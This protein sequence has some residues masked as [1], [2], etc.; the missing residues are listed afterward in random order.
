MKTVRSQLLKIRG[1]LFAILY[2][3]SLGSQYFLVSTIDDSLTPYDIM[4]FRSF[5]FL[6]AVFFISW[7]GCDSYTGKDM[8]LYIAYGFL[9][10][11]GRTFAYLALSFAQVGNVTAIT[12]N[13]S[14]P[15]AILGF[16]V[17]KEVITR[18]HVTVFVINVIGVVFVSKPPIIFQAYEGLGDV[19][20]FIGALMS[21][22]VV[23]TISLAATASRKLSYRR[24]SD[25]P[26]LVFVTGVVG[27]IMTCLIFQF[28]GFHLPSSFPEITKTASVCFISLL[29]NIFLGIALKYETVVVVTVLMSLSLTVAY[30]LQIL[31]L[32]AVPGVYEL[33]GIAL[34]LGTN[35]AFLSKTQNDV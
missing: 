32:H 23:I 11:T 34:I 5:T 6:L 9:N 17:L 19:R 10:A 12:S 14:L 20:E 25:P 26:L 4:F 29:G 35:F 18:F 15:S 28:S 31:I 8:I 3:V 22:V 1:K 2:A 33:A 13:L 30:A 24:A 7:D 27:V 21:L 16:L